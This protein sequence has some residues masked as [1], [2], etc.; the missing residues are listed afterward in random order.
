VRAVGVEE[1]IVIG[2]PEP[3]AALTT[4]SFAIGRLPLPLVL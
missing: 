2:E 3:E 4:P 1:G